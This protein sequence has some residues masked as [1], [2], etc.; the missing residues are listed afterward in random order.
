MLSCLT[1]FSPVLHEVLTAVNRKKMLTAIAIDDEPVALDIVK[2]LAARIS[3]VQ[4]TACFTNAFDAIQYLQQHKVDLI[5]LDIKMPDI[6]GIEFIRSVPNPPM[7]IFATAYSEH[8]VQSFEL[9]A[10]DYL[11]KPFSQARFLKA[12]TKAYEQHRLKNNSRT[13]LARPSYIFI[14]TGTE[15]VRIE[16]CDLLYIESRGNYMQ[17]V[18]EDKKI[19]ARLTMSETEQLLPAGDFIR[20]HRSFIIARKQVTKIDRSNV[21]V[22]G[23]AI[24]IGPAYE[25]EV[26]KIN[27]V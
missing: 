4:I 3:F 17:L 23:A 22:K 20:V 13:D 26:K 10:I 1:A 7:V 2:A 12:C 16:L 15:Q 8:A 14:K 6:S 11:L 18:L 21:W 24:P 9:D 25:N 19:S 27:G 5:F